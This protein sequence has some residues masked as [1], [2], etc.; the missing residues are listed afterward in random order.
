MATQEWTSTLGVW[1]K[2]KLLHSCPLYSEIK[3]TD[4]LD[5]VRYADDMAKNVSTQRKIQE[6]MDRVSQ[7]CES[8]MY[9]CS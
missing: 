2:A 7:A 6:V 3:K 8:Y 4:V 1:F 5:E 9:F